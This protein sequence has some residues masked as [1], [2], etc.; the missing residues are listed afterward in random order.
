[1]PNMYITKDDNFCYDETNALHKE[2]GSFSLVMPTLSYLKSKDKLNN[3]VT[4]D[5]LRS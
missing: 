5:K 2:T 4:I 3:A 1:M